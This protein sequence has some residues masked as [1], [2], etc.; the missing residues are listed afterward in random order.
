MMWI[1]K[2]YHLR[3]K[4]RLRQFDKQRKKVM[5]RWLSLPLAL[6]NRVSTTE[7]T[8]VNHQQ[9][10]RIV[11]VRNNA[12]VGNTLFLIPFINQVKQAYPQ[13]ELTL[14]GSTHWQAS[15]LEGLGIDHFVVSHFRFSSLG[16]LLK[17]I[18]TLRKTQFDLCFMPCGSAQDALMCSTLNARNKIGF[19]HERYRNALTHPLNNPSFYQHAALRC[20]AL[21]PQIAPLALAQTCHQLRLNAQELADGKAARLAIADEQTL[22]IGYFREARGAKQLS[23][24]QW[25][26]ALDALTQ[27]SPRPVVWIEILGPGMKQGFAPNHLSCHCTDLRELAGFLHHLDGFI[28]CDT[29]PLH[30]ADAVN[31][32]CI[33]LFTHTDP[34]VY[35]M[36]GDKAQ[37]ITDIEQFDAA[38]LW[39]TLLGK[40]LVS[41][42]ETELP[43][44]LVNRSVSS[45]PNQLETPAIET[46]RLAL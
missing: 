5:S 36:L 46:A 24:K 45:Q 22:C 28:S 39:P 9:V 12:R 21:I 29:G 1:T 25:H 3:F 26:H 8:L 35:G 44:A 43:L 27:A 19:D 34:A 10:Q 40:S 20:L 7:E 42:Q 16:K 32:P 13:A 6:F 30:L 38:H 15:L 2:E 14:V 41:A 11:I 31:T 23:D 33:G 17:T 37:Y 4:N 18:V